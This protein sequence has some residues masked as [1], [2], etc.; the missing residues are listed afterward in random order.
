[1]L[2]GSR[3]ENGSRSAECDQTMLVKWQA[4]GRI[5]E[6]FELTVEPVW[7]VV[8]DRFD[9]F[10]DFASA[11]SSAAATG[12]VRK[13]DSDP[14]IKSRRQQRRLAIARVADRGDSMRIHIPIGN[15]VI[16]TTMKAPGPRCKRSTIGRIVSRRITVC[17]P[18]IN[19]VA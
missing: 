14:L 5:V 7:K 10:A 9:R 6:L 3:K 2:F 19:A 15:Q 1:I 11:W 17:E 13:G 4:L 16:D 8:V 18:G 12:L